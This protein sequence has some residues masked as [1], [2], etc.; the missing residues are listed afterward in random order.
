MAIMGSIAKTAAVALAEIRWAGRHVRTWVAAALSGGTGLG[1]YNLLSY[2][3]TQFGAVVAPR[4][5]LPG[6]GLI[7]LWVALAGIV[8]LAFDLRVRDEREHISQVVDARPVSNLALMAGRLLAVVWVAW[9]P[10]LLMAVVLQAGGA[11][12]EANEWRVGVAPEP[13]SLASYVFIDAPVAMLFWGAFVMLLAAALPSRLAVAFVGLGLLAAY[14]CLVLNT[15]IYLLP[16][17]TGIANLGLP[18]SDIVARGL[19]VT[20]LSQRCG[21]VGLA[22]G[23]LMVAS[24]VLPRGDSASRPPLSVWGCVLLLVGA[25]GIAAP[26]IQVLDARMDRVSWAEAHRAVADA[27]RPDLE[28]VSGWV[29]I[30]PGRELTMSLDLEVRAPDG[31]ALEDLSFSLNP[32]VQGVSVRFNG[33]EVGFHHELGLLTVVL[34]APLAADARAVVSIQAKGIPDPRFGYLDEAFD[35]LD[36]SLL[37]SPAVVMGDQAS[38]FGRG[39]VALMPAVRWLPMPGAHQ[40]TGPYAARRPDLHLIDLTVSLPDGWH[41]AGPGRTR[42]DGVFRFQPV[43]E[44]AE[45]PLIAAPFERRVRAF[46]GIEYELLIHPKH[47]AAADYFVDGANAQFLEVNLK[48]RLALFPGALY[49]H[50]T[51]SLVEVPGQLRRYGGGW[52]MDAVQGLPGVQMVPEHSFPTR[53]YAAEKS[54]QGVSKSVHYFRHFFVT[55]AR[56]LNGIP[57]SAGLARNALLS[58]SCAGGDSD[59]ALTVLLDFL[60]GAMFRSETVLAPVHWLQ[61]GRT[62]GAP[63]AVRVLHRLTGTATM[64]HVWTPSLP[65]ELWVGPRA[66]AITDL[67]PVASRDAADILI[68]SGYLV[69]RAIVDLVGR[70]KVGEFLELL[71][72]RHGGGTCRLEEF[73]SGLSEVSASA[74]FYAE[75]AMRSAG[76]PGFVTST[77]RISRVTDDILGQPRYQILID[78]RNAEAA[79]GVVSMNWFRASEEGWGVGFV[80]RGHTS[81]ELGLVA[82]V[83]PLELNLNTYLSL[84]RKSIRLPVRHSETVSGGAPFV[85]SRPSKWQPADPGIVVDDLDAGFSVAWAGTGTRR[86]G[87]GQTTGQSIGAVPEYSHLESKPGWHRQ[88]DELTVGWGRYRRTLVRTPAGSGDASASFTTDLPQAGTWRL[89]YHL[90]GTRISHG[91]SGWGLPDYF[92]TLQ[93]EVVAVGF[94]SPVT[95]DGTTAEQGW[96][97]VGTFDLPAGPVTVVVTDASDGDVVVAD[98]VHWQP[99]TAEALHP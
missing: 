86:L 15:P 3:H 45:F 85:G 67:D 24:N 93:I 76:L 19:G 88:E 31:T 2:E 10:V 61:A 25:A 69:S 97:F 41:A 84:N 48:R 83:P 80:V 16:T 47:V 35:P 75:H 99:E 90:P 12:V 44:L 4:F 68:D 7:V 39:Y 78:V 8:L 74:A 55:D 70:G 56:G 82:P 18:G 17:A 63:L 34:P 73:L 13:V 54:P 71:E 49:P 81:L 79:P 32:G 23:L 65:M 40:D 1:L 46:D 5:W 30:D 91:V 21:V 33:E 14:A 11:I 77:P 38:L 37:G 66:F 72:Q 87:N 28:R 43:M 29:S 6:I 60:A 96:N 36:E 26:A 51:L 94:R 22:I 62:P 53:R 64:R 57:L 42:Q 59:H 52:L 92:G 27:P 9:L 98:A 20:D 95:L 89:S 50:D 58:R